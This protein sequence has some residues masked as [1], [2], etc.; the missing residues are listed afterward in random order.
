MLTVQC[1]EVVVEAATPLA[2]DT[3]CGSALRGAFFRA[4]W[5]RFCTNREAPECSVCPLVDCCPVSSIV[6]P[7]RDEAVRGRDVPRP[8]VISPPQGQESGRYEPGQTLSFGF[9]LIGSSTKLFPYVVRS[10]QEME[11]FGFGHPLP[12]T[13]Q[14]GRIRIRE[15]FAHH[16]FTGERQLLWEGGT[17]HIQRAQVCVTQDDISARAERLAP[18]RVTLL[19]LSPTR[20]IANDRL[21]W[22]PDFRVLALRL[23]E[24]FEQLQREYSAPAVREAVTTDREWY[25]RVGTMAGNVRLVSDETH[26]VDL[27]SYST[28][29]KQ[30]TQIGGFMGRVSFEGDITHLR[31]LLV[32]GEVLHVGKNAVKGDGMYRVEV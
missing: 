30:M 19:F 26:W 13:N 28:R 21:L 11:Q 6:A 24:R 15:V 20:L 27:K 1:L 23:A 4:I 14:R 17:T 29:R 8:Y 5:G 22:C 31:E 2:L 18:D 7:L 3:H 32:W 12:D 16:P 9:T 10:I 25:L